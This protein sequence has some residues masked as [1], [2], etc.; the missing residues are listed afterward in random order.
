[1]KKDTYLILIYKFQY[2]H[3]FLNFLISAIFFYGG[4]DLNLVHCIYYA[5]SLSTEVNS[6][7]QRV[8]ICTC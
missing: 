3:T 1:M 7:G 5:L 6:R 2:K 4:R 8:Q